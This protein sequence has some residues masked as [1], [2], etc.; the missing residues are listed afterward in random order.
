MECE[1]T[2]RDLLLPGL[3]AILVQARLIWPSIK[4]EGDLELRGDELWVTVSKVGTAIT[5]SHRVATPDEL[6]DGTYK[7][8]FQPTLINIVETLATIH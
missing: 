8:A 7:Y 5:L 1:P 6:R 4:W 2:A 3:A